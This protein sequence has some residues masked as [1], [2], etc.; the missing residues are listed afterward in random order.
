VQ[1]QTANGWEAEI[2][3]RKLI[4]QLGSEERPKGERGRGRV[5]K[6]R[7]SFLFTSSKGGDWLKE[8]VEF[9]RGRSSTPEK[10]ASRGGRANGITSSEEDFRGRNGPVREANSR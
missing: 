4:P 9:G 8:R 2:K 1:A 7:P 5:F 10:G 6:E 3:R